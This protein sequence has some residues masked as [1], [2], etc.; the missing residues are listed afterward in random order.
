MSCLAYRIHFVST[1]DIELDSS[2][3]ICSLTACALLA[4]SSLLLPYLR[5]HPTQSASTTQLQHPIDSPLHQ[6]H[7]LT[8]HHH[9]QTLL[10]H[11]QNTTP[12]TYSSRPGSNMEAGRNDSGG[13]LGLTQ[14]RRASPIVRAS[15]PGQPG[16]DVSHSPE[17]PMPDK[18][19]THR[20]KYFHVGPRLDS[21]EFI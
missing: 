19:P 9:N 8:L 17:F 6:H 16:D 7:H 10:S 1:R 20:Y 2:R 4:C 5:K 21:N 18:C 14:G 13:R 11:I 12:T 15:S 3:L